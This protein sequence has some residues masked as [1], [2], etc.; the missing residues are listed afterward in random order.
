MAFPERPTSSNPL[1]EHGH[2]PVLLA[3]VL[4]LLGIQAG[5]T[6]VDCTVG[7]GGHSLAIAGAV[8]KEGTL[9]GIDGDPE[10]LGY[11]KTRLEGSRATVRLFH[12]RFADVDE[13]LEAAGSPRVDAILADLGVSTNQLLDGKYGLS[14][15]NPGPLDMRLDPR[16][17]RSAADL[18]NIMRE[19]DLANLIFELGEERHS[20]KIARKIVEVRRESPI[21]TSE[22]LAD[23]VRSVVPREYGPRGSK[24]D[25]A[26]RTF[27]A[28][29]MAVNDE[30]GQLST[31][32]E[33]VPTAVAPGGRVG[34]ISF[35]SGE[36]RLVKQCFNML[37]ESGSF[38]RV[39]RKPVVA[40][41]A[42]LSTNPRARSAK[43]RVVQK[44]G[45]SPN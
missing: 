38:E 23:L 43:F 13:V 1:P 37:G 14:F 34:I 29:R 33:K 16:I 36:D 7:R 9:I 25:P 3:E 5:M 15:S 10:N 18:V 26:T 28:L 24:I 12:A 32:L 42:E 17:D 30:L 2:E 39:T 22:R 44:V 20:R 35:H 19:D 11:A 8:G 31:F 41:E 45:D 40:G 27:M 4:D 6:V 21:N